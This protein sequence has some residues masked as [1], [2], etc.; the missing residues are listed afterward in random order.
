MLIAVENLLGDSISMTQGGVQANA[1]DVIT[2]ALPRG[3]PAN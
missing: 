1:L 3:E 2:Q